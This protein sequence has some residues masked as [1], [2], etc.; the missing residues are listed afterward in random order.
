M[1]KGREAYQH[2]DVGVDP[3]GV[4]M[5]RSPRAHPSV[6]EDASLTFRLDSDLQLIGGRCWQVWSMV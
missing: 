5:S 2:R 1:T 4:R 6:F 3:E